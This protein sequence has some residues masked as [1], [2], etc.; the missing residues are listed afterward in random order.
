MIKHLTIKGFK[1]FAE[2][3]FKLSPLTVLT[4]LN[5]SGKSSVIQALRMLDKVARGESNVLLKGYGSWQDLRCSHSDSVMLTEQYG[6][7]GKISLSDIGP[8]QNSNTEEIPQVIYVSAGRLG[9]QLSMPMTYDSELDSM[10]ANVV[11]IIEAYANSQMD[12]CM[13]RKDS[14]VDSFEYV[15][16]EWLNIICPGVNFEEKLQNSVQF[17]TFDGH[18]PLNVGFGLSYTLTVIVAL[19]VASVTKATVLIENPEAHLHPRGQ[20]DMAELVSKTVKSGAQV[21]VETHSDHFFDG[22]RVYVKNHSSMSEKIVAYWMSL[23]DN[24]LS[25]IEQVHILP[26]GRV[27]NWP[28]GMFDQFE[29]NAEQLL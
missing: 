6:R 13:K 14:V 15:L 20:S 27:D 12:D 4:G 19:L 26:N 11:E 1:S 28:H 21:I 25:K 10:G 16:K 22:L 17:M 5:S 8:V 7:D 18:T 2:A 23:D 24:R 3:S 29:L 9:P